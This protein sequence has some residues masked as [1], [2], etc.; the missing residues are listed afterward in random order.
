MVS[1][2]PEEVVRLWRLGFAIHWLRP[3]SKIPVQSGWT[4]GERASLEEL[5]QTFDRKYNFGV[6]LG[7][8]S[9]VAGGYLAVVDVDIKGSKK[10]DKQEALEAVRQIFPEIT[11]G[12]WLRSGRGNGSRH[13]YVRTGEPTSGDETKA[14]S[15]RL[16]RVKMPSVPPN[17]KEKAKLTPHELA[18]G[19]RLRPAWEVSLLSEGR[20][21]A[22]VGSIHPDTGEAY[23]WGKPVG[24]SGKDTPLLELAPG[25]RKRVQDRLRDAGDRTHLR[26]PERA[27]EFDLTDVEPDSLPLTND[28]RAALVE[29][30]RVTDRSAKVYELC[31]VL[32]A[33]GVPDEQILSVMT[34]RGLYLGACAFDHAKTTNRQ[35]A[36]RWVEK[37]CLRKA[38]SRVHETPFDVEELP[39]VPPDS[40]VKE[41][42]DKS[43]STK[44]SKKPPAK[45]VWP[46]GFSGDDLPWEQ[47]LEL[48]FLGGNKAPV[49]K[50]TLANIH[51]VLA[52]RAPRPDF[53][54]LE[55]FS[56]RVVWQCDTPWGCKAG[57]E[58]SGDNAD[59]VKIKSWFAEEYK[60]EP[61]NVTI[62]EALMLIADHHKFHVVKDYLGSLV[63]DGQ[64]RIAGAFKNYLGAVMPEP[65][66]SEVSRKF[67]L[68]CVKRIYE[69][70][71]K[72]D[73]VVVLEGRQGLGKSTFA[74]IL[75]SEA[76]FLDGLPNFQD[77]DAALNL[78][79]AWICELGELATLYKS[80]NEATK[81]F[82]TRRTDRVRPPYGQRRVEFPRST[83]F[84]GTT[85][86]H[87]YFTDST[88]NR[89]F[90][91]V[92][93]RHCD[94]HA[95]HRDRDQLWAEAVWR[96]F[97][98]PE[99]LYLKDDVL[100]Q[101]EQ[102]QELRRVEDEGDS[103]RLLLRNWLKGEEIEGRDV[104]SLNLMELFQ[105]L[106]WGILPAN[107]GN[108]MRG[109]E[110]LKE[111]G[112]RKFHVRKGSIWK[113][114]ARR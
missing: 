13:Y 58:R 80:A 45:R 57:R 31:I 97:F 87:V 5:E 63:W 102:V 7:R 65:Y 1:K 21:A 74:S 33:A 15:P 71:C 64:D 85:N 2:L 98:Q 50:C 84:M 34:Q 48:K 51:L 30:R 40:K 56:Q 47:Q 16:V 55:E 72:F 32:T 77:K 99:P 23:R 12:P 107:R 43:N 28:Q 11:G 81:A 109:G 46:E 35:R 76:W 6:R 96:H 79:G 60:V 70:G 113:L 88:G 39:D 75:A 108:V 73:Y 67:F 92:K 52:N 27:P 110:I 20:Q 3:K 9:R 78:I 101:A 86:Q 37:Y 42:R 41:A 8:A 44:A 103:M 49:I 100:H 82:I 105:A 61:S 114:T 91:P 89:R 54:R 90:W 19:W 93:V 18:E 25:D 66:L 112:Y 38:K 53:L 17:V 111:F 104:S 94:F 68:G 62:D 95:V 14:R 106:P 83:V 26:G 59:A 22:I 4:K 69:P 36:A 24:G 29:G 10:R